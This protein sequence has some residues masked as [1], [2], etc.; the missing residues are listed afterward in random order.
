VVLH[1]EGNFHLGPFHAGVVPRLDL[2]RPHFARAAL[3]STRL[4]FE[5]ARTAVETLTSVGFAACAV[6]ATGEV[7]VANPNFESEH[8]H[9]TTR[10]GNRIALVDR[11]A[12]RQLQEALQ[13]LRS[14]DGVRS[15]P[16]RPRDEVPPAILHMVPI[17]RSAHDLFARASAI[18]V[19][20]QPSEGSPQSTPMLQALFD[21]SA[22]EA[23]IAAR[24]AN[25]QT[26]EAI[27]LATS[28]SVL[29]VRN[30][31]KSA[32]AK[33]GCH[34]QTDLVRLLT[35]LMSASPQTPQ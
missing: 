9:W 14:A 35:Q 16:L 22:A 11:R 18:L 4:A 30:Q 8:R 25:G 12:D 33:T 26:I 20:T 19:L 27:A 7:L 5:R 28:R 31:V 34:R 3:I 21:L 23:D 6:Q 15:V 2:L 32:M 13:H 1:G 17:R 29:T 10:G 24:L